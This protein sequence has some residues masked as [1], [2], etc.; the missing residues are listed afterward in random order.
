MSTNQLTS[1]IESLLEWVKIMAEAKEEAESLRDEIKQEMI[2]RNTEELAAGQYIVR[3]TSVLT[4][5]FDANAFKKSMP[6]VYKSFIKQIASR[7]FSIA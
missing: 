5:R 6:E 4:Q 2:R 1:K 3:W 7:R